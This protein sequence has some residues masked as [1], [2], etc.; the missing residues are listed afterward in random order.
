MP[1]EV[2]HCEVCDHE[3]EVEVAAGKK[4]RGRVRNGNRKTGRGLPGSNRRMRSG[5]YR[6]P[7][8]DQAADR[9][10]RQIL[11]HGAAAQPTPIVAQTVAL[12]S[13]SSTA[14]CSGSDWSMMARTRRLAATMSRLRMRCLT[15][16]M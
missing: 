4:R 6:R 8:K 1:T 10:N 9:L 12:K 7:G 3:F 11:D 15:R 14:T 2:R 13:S 5:Q 16:G